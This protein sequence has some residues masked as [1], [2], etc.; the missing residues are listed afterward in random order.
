L[1]RVGTIFEVLG[2]EAGSWLARNFATPALNEMAYLMNPSAGKQGVPAPQYP[3]MQAFRHRTPGVTSP[4]RTMSSFYSFT[5]PKERM[6]HY[7]EGLGL[8]TD[9]STKLAYN[10]AMEVSGD[11]GDKINDRLVPYSGKTIKNS[12]AVEMLNSA[13]VAQKMLQDKVINAE[14]GSQIWH[15]TM[16]HAAYNSYMA[17]SLANYNNSSTNN[18]HT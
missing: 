4:S 15:N 16:E 9:T 11:T 17:K 18:S 7:Y 5:N 13:N 3:T 2:T 1:T 12:A 14:R 8:T 10:H 6:I